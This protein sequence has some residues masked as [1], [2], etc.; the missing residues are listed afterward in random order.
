MGAAA[1]CGEHSFMFTRTVFPEFPA[2]RLPLAAITVSPVLFCSTY[3]LSSQKYQRYSDFCSCCSQPL[4]HGERI[5][6]RARAGAYTTSRPSA[7]IRMAVSAPQPENAID[8]L[9][10]LH[11]LKVQI[12]KP[13]R[14]P[15]LSS[16]GMAWLIQQ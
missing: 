13:G 15:Q 9:T 10:L 1:R 2:F 4:V 16:R 14:L 12:A 11:N 7:A 3:P 8:F 5:N 6:I